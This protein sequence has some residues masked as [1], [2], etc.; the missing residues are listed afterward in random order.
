[1]ASSL[2]LRVR[3]PAG[4]STLSLPA[5]AT[6]S[7]AIKAVAERAGVALERLEL[8]SGF[9]LRVLDWRAAPEDASAAAA[10]GL[11]TGESLQ[12]SEAAETVRAVEAAQPAPGTVPDAVLL[13]DSSGFAVQRRIVASDNTCLFRA[14]AYIMSQD[15][16]GGDAL[17]AVVAAAVL[18]DPEQYC[19]AVLGRPPSEYADWIQR[20]D[21]WGGAIELAIL[22]ANFGTEL[23]AADI[24]TKAR[25]RVFCTKAA[26]Y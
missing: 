13:G 18:A 8:R 2:V 3:G 15:R 6:V 1:M 10:L 22:S 26:S 23:C 20:G 19:E 14:A 16:T 25:A 24:Q 12:A 5:D 17:R 4:Q 9:P 11:A 21:S 7:A